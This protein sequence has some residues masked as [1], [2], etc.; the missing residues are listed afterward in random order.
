MADDVPRILRPMADRLRPMLA[1]F[2]PGAGDLSDEALEALLARVD[3]RLAA[4]EPS[5]GRRLRLFVRVL[6]LF[7]L[8]GYGR[9]FRGL[10]PARRTEFCAR[11]EKSRIA[12]LRVGLWGLRTLLFL[13]WYGDPEVQA[14][15]GY[16][17]D[18]RGWEAFEAPGRGAP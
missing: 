5:L 3:E 17:P 14:R 4:E 10:S 15:L 9:T 16:R 6:D 12:L 2:V 11:V 1:T 8:L 13:G 7:P 18:P